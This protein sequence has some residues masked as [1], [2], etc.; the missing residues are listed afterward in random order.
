V[1]QMSADY[2]GYADHIL[3]E[4]LPDLRYRRH[5]GHPSRTTTPAHVVPTRRAYLARACA[6]GIRH[7]LRVPQCE[8]KGVHRNMLTVDT[9]PM[10]PIIVNFAKCARHLLH[11]KVLYHSV[12]R[13]KV[14]A[15]G[16]G[17]PPLHPQ[18]ILIP[19]KQSVGACCQHAVSQGCGHR[20]FPK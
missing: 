1:L 12:R 18:C 16:T 10:F 3:I 17:I 19:L 8:Y 6:R 20:D 7:H 9:F 15:A 11:Y 5:S 2:T 14:R 4:F 13:R